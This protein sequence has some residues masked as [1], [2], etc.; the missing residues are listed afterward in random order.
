MMFLKNRLVL[1]KKFLAYERL[2]SRIALRWNFLRIPILIPEIG[3]VDFLFELDQ[4]IPKIG[5][6]PRLLEG[7]KE[8]HLV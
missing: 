3:D 2:L 6:T 5:L 1:E 4:K 7:T 8:F